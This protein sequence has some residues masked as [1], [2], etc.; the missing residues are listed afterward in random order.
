MGSW[1]I[2]VDGVRY[3]GKIRRT[4]N[5]PINCGVALWT[6]ETYDEIHTAMIQITAPRTRF[7]KVRP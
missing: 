3:E 4:D 5:V 1:Y 6:L 2:R 7:R